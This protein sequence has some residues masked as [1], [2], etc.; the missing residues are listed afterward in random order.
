MKPPA[1][2]DAAVFGR[3][4]LMQ[5]P[6][7]FVIAVVL[8]L[9]V[10]HEQLSTGIALAIFGLW[11]V[12]EIALFPVMRIGYE[13][14]ETHA[15]VEALVGAVGIAQDDLDPEGSVRLGAER[16]RAVVDGTDGFVPA[17][18]EVRVREVRQLTLIVELVDDEAEPV[19]DLR[20]C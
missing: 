4:A 6:S 9:L 5:L 10:H 8:A 13:A 19:S 3:Y 20:S 17:G 14:G 11:I 15:G 7:G 2:S 18:A 1:P 12:V 16:W